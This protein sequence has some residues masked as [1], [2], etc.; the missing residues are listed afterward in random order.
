[1]SQKY[2]LAI[3]SL[4]GLLLASCAPAATPFAPPPAPTVTAR[5]EQLEPLVVPSPTALATEALT[6]TPE[7]FALNLTPLPT[8]TAIP[9]LQL[10]TEAPRQTVLQAWDGRP[11]YLADS[12]PDYYFRVEFDPNAWALTLDYY[13]APSL[14]H[15]AIRN[16]IIAPT[17]GHGL[18]PNATVSQEVRKIGEIDY[19][20]SAVSLNGVRQSVIYTGGDGRILS[21]F[22][23]SLDERPD[24]CLLEAEAVLGT[25]SS[26][27]ISEATPIAT[28]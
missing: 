9:T 16:C 4:T 12:N 17:T 23:V 18:P 28:P 1:M 13:G 26:V 15:R 7:P 5:P 10:P 20:I 11:T 21:A 2:L 8:E 25:L 3:L 6:P 14:V 19:Q 22:Q 27:P 24:Q